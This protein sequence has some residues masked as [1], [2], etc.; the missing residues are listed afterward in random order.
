MGLLR[1]IL[2]TCAS[3]ENVACKNAPSK[4]LC[5]VYFSS[6]F[7]LP[8]IIHCHDFSQQKPQP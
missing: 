4:L 8:I 3:S 6:H 5:I 1:L 2:S 7:L